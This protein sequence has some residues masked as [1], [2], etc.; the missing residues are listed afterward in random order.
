MQYKLG[1]LFG[2]GNALP[3]RARRSPALAGTGAVGAVL[4]PGS[5]AALVKALETVNDGRTLTIPKVLV[6]NQQAANLNSVLQTPFASTNASTTV[7]T[8][9]FGGTQDA[10]TQISV[11]PRITEGDE[12]SLDYTITLSSF[13]G[14]AA[15]PALPPPRQ[16]NML[17]STATIPDGFTVAVG[18]LEVETEGT[19]SRRVPILGSIPIL[20]ALFSSQSKTKTKSHFYVFLQDER[21]AQPD[22]RG[23]A[24]RERAGPRGGQ[25]RRWVAEGAG[26]DHPMRRSLTTV[27]LA[28]L[29]SLTGC[30]TQN[31]RRP[32]PGPER[33]GP[34]DERRREAEPRGRRPDRL[35]TP[36]R[37][38]RSCAT[39]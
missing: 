31:T 3:E 37:P 18:G 15:S 24:L 36:R 12:L 19:T 17:K 38:S 11:T 22:V 29:A 20:G 26:E 39:H 6:T 13:V 25:G 21:P 1:S 10:G 14:D 33:G 27:V 30:R 16:Q 5:F 7:A 35:E 34:R 32:L 4:D 2:L 28:A 23:P 9:S 8:T